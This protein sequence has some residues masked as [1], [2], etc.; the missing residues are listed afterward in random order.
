MKKIIMVFGIFCGMIMLNNNTYI[1]NASNEKDTT[2]MVN[3]LVGG[4][5]NDKYQGLTQTADGGYIVVGSSN[6]KDG[7]IAISKGSYDALLTKYD[8]YG[9]CE[10]VK[11]IGGSGMD[12]FYS[13]TEVVDGYI[14]VGQTNSKDGDLTSGSL[15]NLDG[16]VVK[17][18]KN[19]NKQWDKRYGGSLN[20]SLKSIIT[21]KSGD[22]VILGESLKT[23]PT[24]ISDKFH[25]Y[26]DILALK[27]DLD[28][29]KKW[30]QVYGGTDF[31]FA[32]N[33]IETSDGNIVFSGETYSQYG[34]FTDKN[35]GNDDGLLVKLDVNTGVPIWDSLF[36][37]TGADT[38]HS[39]V[40][41]S[42]GDLIAVGNVSLSPDGEVTDSSLGNQDM[43]VTKFDENGKYIWDQVTGTTGYDDGFG[44]D[45]DKDDNIIVVGSSAGSGGE[46][47]DLSNGD[48]DALVLKIGDNG[49]IIDNDLFGGTSYEEFT[50]MIVTDD[51]KKIII[52]NSNSNDGEITAKNHGSKDAMILRDNLSKT[53]NQPV[54]TGADDI[55]INDLESFDPKKGV[56]AMDVEDGD[57]TDKIEINVE[58]PRSSDD[59]NYVYSVKDSDD[60]TTIVH[61][62]VTVVSNEKPI[63]TGADAITIKVDEEFDPMNGVVAT[64][65]EDGDLTDKIII[66]YNNLDNTKAGSY[67]ITYSVTDSDSNITKVDRTIKVENDNIITPEKPKEDDNSKLTV[68]G[69][70]VT[71]FYLLIVSAL[72]LLVSK[73]I[74]KKAV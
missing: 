38:F 11:T 30:D 47:T 63:I 16:L 28:G 65:V 27:L 15:G 51:N 22:V 56:T 66:E 35:N 58:S 40:E 6:S 53:N 3:E 5:A 18:D 9:N 12:E 36:G 48:T 26:Q 29:N 1:L 33:V 44:I 64:D 70:G 59:Y 74:I 41:N 10:W 2:S 67:T 31:E 52:G 32:G 7:D 57:L 68:T 73:K 14:A 25:G 49:S 55:T 42:K 60:N 17:F 61:R 4:S 46:V 54:I 37:T 8:K 13:V 34:E 20:D 21:T 69:K 43:L 19:G 62:K 45:I 39:V 71:S 23:D 24:I 72:I 50:D